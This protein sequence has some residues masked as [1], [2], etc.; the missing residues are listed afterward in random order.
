MVGA[1]ASRIRIEIEQSIPSAAH[2]WG[3]SFLQ[4]I[5]GGSCGLYKYV[6]PMTQP[7]F[8]TLD[9]IRNLPN[10]SLSKYKHKF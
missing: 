6:G 9:S 8:L 3:C 10:L 2:L 1:F 7:T 5:W 4:S